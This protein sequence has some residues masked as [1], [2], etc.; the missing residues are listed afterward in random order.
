VPVGGTWQR[1]LLRD[2]GRQTE[3]LR[4]DRSSTNSVMNKPQRTRIIKIAVFDEGRRLFRCPMIGGQRPWVGTEQEAAD[5]AVL[6]IQQLY[7]RNRKVWTPDAI[8]ELDSIVAP[9]RSVATK[10]CPGATTSAAAPVPSPSHKVPPQ[11]VVAKPV[12]SLTLHDVIEVYAKQVKAGGALSESGQMRRQITIT[13]LMARLKALKR[14]APNVD[15][16]TA[17]YDELELVVAK[18]AARPPSKTTGKPISAV[19]AS[20]LVSAMRQILDWL[21]ASDRWDGPRRWMRLFRGK[22]F[23]AL[24]TRREMSEQQQR[25]S[26]FSVE[27]LR[28]IYQAASDTHRLLI[29]TALNIGATQME[30]AT[31][32][33]SELHNGTIIR[34][35]EKTGVE[36]RWQM[37]PETSRLLYLWKHA[38]ASG[39]VLTVAAARKPK[40]DSDESVFV[41]RCGNPLVHFGE[42]GTRIDTITCKWRKLM[43]TLETLKPHFKGLT[44]KALRKTGSQMVRDLGQSSE[45]TQAYLSHAEMSVSGRHYN[46]R[47][48]ATWAALDAVMQRVYDEKIKP[49]IDGAPPAGWFYTALERTR[50]STRRKGINTRA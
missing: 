41:S 5:L 47:S 25:R 3:L 18:L 28:T 42:Q 19:F 45:L 48:D 38:V 8:I 33:W 34:F 49:I 35:R 1:A 9:F 16:R 21:E 12:A 43:S 10:V 6:R 27:D 17:T 14:F 32:R 29:L 39:E 30:L 37:W 13:G 31:L 26:H 7:E 22:T 11:Q 50:Q 24:T 15:L 20:S 40:I 44:F 4:K 23:R 2:I 36:G 46:R